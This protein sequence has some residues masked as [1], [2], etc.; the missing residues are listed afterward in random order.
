MA[1]DNRGCRA[2]RLPQFAGS[3]AAALFLCDAGTAA[4]QEATSVSGVTVKGQPP[5]GYK[6]DAPALSKLTESVIDT[7]QMLS[8][9]PR[10]VIEDRGATSL[11]EVFRNSSGI[12]L[13]AGESSWQ[14]TNLSIRGFNA[15]NDMY[16]DGMR[17]F[18]SYTRDPFNLEEVELLQGPSSILFGRGSTGGVVNQVSKTPTLQGFIRGEAVGGTDNLARGT[19]DL[20]APLPQLG[21]G[22]AVRVAAMAHTQEFTDRDQARYRRE[23]VAPSLAFGLGTATRLT[24]SYLYQWEDDI[25]D[26]GLPYFRGAP[27][28]VARNNFYGFDSDYLRTRANVATAR[29]EHDFSPDITFRDQLR[30]ADYG[31]HWRDTEPQVITTGVTSATPLS[32]IQVNRALQGGTSRETFLQNQMDV[33][34]TFRTGAIEHHLA[35]GWEVGPESSKPTYDNGL[36]IPATSLLT[37]TEGQPFS[38]IDLPRVKVSTTADTV[39]VYLIDTLKFGPHWEVSGGVRWDRFSSH[40]AAQFFGNT[41]ATLNQPTTSQDV[42]QTDEKPSWRGSV[43]YKPMP[44]GSIYFDYSTSFNPSA[45]AL[46]QIVAVRSFNVGNIGLAPETNE[47]FEVGTKWNLLANRLQLQG[48]IFHEEKQNARVPDPTNS[49]VNILAGDQRVDGAEVELAG[50]VTDAWQVTASYTYLDGKTIKTVPGGPPLN[51]P[52]F[53]APRDSAALWTTYQLPMRIEIGGGVNYL[54]RRFAS[55]TTVPFTSV[56][57]YTTLDLMA[58]WQATDH[59]RLQVNVNNVT[60]KFFFDQ[61]HGFH[62]VPGEGRTALFTLAYTD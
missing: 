44:N 21:E 13:G 55:L 49:A 38:G 1:D 61:V 37:P 7:P 56:P 6:A 18:G 14:G 62:V 41:V 16:L 42:H 47:T 10:Q 23:G 22:A 20:D 59:I 33:L 29:F 30:Y 2:S 32:A 35:A 8:I 40:Y 28:P 3:I 48:A 51:S 46:S 54:S 9:T 45:E 52:L 58:K 26:Y 4:A 12:S 39:G 50:K 27:A 60:D 19:V 25:P 53:N 5:E 15:R 57:G 17:D 34:A 24:L 31:R 36:N 43:V 11:S